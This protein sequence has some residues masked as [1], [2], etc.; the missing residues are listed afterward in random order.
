MPHKVTSMCIPKQCTSV[1]SNFPNSMTQIDNHYS[2][3]FIYRS[4]KKGASILQS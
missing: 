4:A 3:Q 1:F 2:D